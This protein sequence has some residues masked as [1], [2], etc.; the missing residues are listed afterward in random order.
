MLTSDER[1]QLDNFHEAIGEV[2]DQY[3]KEGL[4]PEWIR[5]ILSN[6][7]TSDLSGRLKELT[8]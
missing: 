4:G 2:I 8:E 6:H 7:E 5:S 3:L 1:K